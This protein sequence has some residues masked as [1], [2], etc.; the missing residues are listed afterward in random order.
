MGQTPRIWNKIVIRLWKVILTGNKPGDIAFIAARC[1]WSWYR[2]ACTGRP[3]HHDLQRPCNG[4]H[5]LYSHSHSPFSHT[6]FTCSSPTSFTHLFHP[7]INH[8]LH[9]HST[10]HIILPILTHNVFHLLASSSFLHVSY[11]QPQFTY[12]SSQTYFL[13]WPFWPHTPHSPQ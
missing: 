3:A 5:P 6:C 11:A 2:T 10:L 12:I 8:F 4:W 7:F 9:S 1:L 13:Q